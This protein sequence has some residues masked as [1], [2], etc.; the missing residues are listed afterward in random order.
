M[1]FLGNVIKPQMKQNVHTAAT[2]AFY[3]LAS[4]ILK[5][6]S[7]RKSVPMYQLKAQYLL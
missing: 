6:M 5:K 4:Q 2:L 3:I 1:T 7:I